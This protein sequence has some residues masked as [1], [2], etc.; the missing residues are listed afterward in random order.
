MSAPTAIERNQPDPARQSVLFEMNSLTG[1]QR[2]KLLTSSITPRPIAWVTTVSATG[3]LNAAPFSCFNMMGHTP[4]M[5]VNTAIQRQLNFGGH[6]S[7]VYLNVDNILDE[8]PPYSYGVGGGING[9]PAYDRK[10]T[11]FKLGYRMEF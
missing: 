2:Y 10:G 8:A 3:T 5:V 9:G 6:K 11:R 7:L 4:P 1:T